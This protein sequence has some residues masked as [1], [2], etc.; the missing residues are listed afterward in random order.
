M[1]PAPI[2]ARS[3]RSLVSSSWNSWPGSASFYRDFINVNGS[4]LPKIRVEEMAPELV[5]ALASTTALAS[6]STSTSPS[7]SSSASAFNFPLLPLPLN[8]RDWSLRQAGYNRHLKQ[9]QLQQTWLGELQ[10]PAKE[11][12]YSQSKEVRRL[13]KRKASNGDYQ[14]PLYRPSISAGW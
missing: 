6:T 9:L 13:L 2:D 10:S 5:N 3:T 12:S 4:P 14:G 7:P 8:R 11:R 1:R